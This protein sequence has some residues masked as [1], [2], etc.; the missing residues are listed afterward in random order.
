M[1]NKERG[2]ATEKDLEM[3]IKE[4]RSSGGGSLDAR[5]ALE[6]LVDRLIHGNGYYR[7]SPLGQG[8]E[9]VWM[10]RIP[11]EDLDDEAW[12]REEDAEF[13][14]FCRP[15]A[16]I[17]AVA[18]N[19]KEGS[20]D[21]SAYVRE[22]KCCKCRRDVPASIAKMSEVQLKLHRLKRKV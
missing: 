19:D 15:G 17:E 22:N 1:A 8:G 18:A 6:I 16:F 7:W 12:L 21:Y 5:R 3:T 9:A 20:A 14:H 10:I 13:L 11:R 4:A 2:D